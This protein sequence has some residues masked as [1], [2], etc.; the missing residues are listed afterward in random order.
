MWELCGAGSNTSLKLTWKHNFV[1]P[2][3]DYF[4]KRIPSVNPRWSSYGADSVPSSTLK[5][6]F[7][8]QHREKRFTGR[9][10]IYEEK[11]YV[12]GDPRAKRTDD[13]RAL[14]EL[15]FGYYEYS[16]G[17]R[18]P[19]V[20][21]LPASC[22]GLSF[23]ADLGSLELEEIEKRAEEER[24]RDI[25]AMKAGG[26]STAKR[27]SMAFH[28]GTKMSSM[29]KDIEELPRGDR[30]SMAGAGAG[31]PPPPF[32]PGEARLSGARRSVFGA[33]ASI[34]QKSSRAS[35]LKSQRYAVTKRNSP[36]GNA[37]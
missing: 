3:P 19:N 1:V 14:T 18:W 16:F 2:I 15:E 25:E 10:T 5:D 22:Y 26:G 36:H 6:V 17:T 23:E 20:N 37:A 24:L 30:G 34:Q 28:Y 12:L 33:Q 7:S 31:D 21:Y 27:G 4:Y 11:I 13:P 9:E 8:V 35:R 29:D 32:A